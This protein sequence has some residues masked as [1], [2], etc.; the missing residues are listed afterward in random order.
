MIRDS[1]L[2]IADLVDSRIG[3]PSVHPPIQEGVWRPFQGGDDWKTPEVG[4]ADRYRRSI[5]TYWKRSIPYPFLVAFDS[6]TRE[7]CTAR[8]MNSNT[9][10]Q[11]LMTLNDRTFNECA[12][13]I[14]E[15]LMREFAASEVFEITG[16][17][18]ARID[19]RTSWLWQRILARTPSRDEREMLR[20]FVRQEARA[21]KK[22][23][24]DT[25]LWSKV[26]L[27]LLNHDEFF[28]N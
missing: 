10:L 25:S 16:G 2:A 19:T 12:T 24:N 11:P 3:G 28:S 6:P 22:N 18:G 20:D 7:F 23:W 5:Y 13:A 8:R 4:K 21:D 1:A 27:L 14:A 26:V 17:D 15:G 9:P